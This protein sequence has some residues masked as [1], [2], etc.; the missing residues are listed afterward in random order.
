MVSREVLE[1][2]KNN[3]LKANDFNIS[4]TVILRYLITQAEHS[5]NN[6][7]NLLTREEHEIKSELY[8]KKLIINNLKNSFIII[9][10]YREML[11][12]IIFIFS[13]S[14]AINLVLRRSF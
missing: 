1:P 8:W 13:H 5:K 10:L 4:R 12:D 14:A 3:L 6:A 9:K 2:V 11:Y 7:S